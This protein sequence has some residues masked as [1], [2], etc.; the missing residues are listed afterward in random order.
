MDCPFIANPIDIEA[1]MIRN[2]LR[3]ERFFRPRQDMFYFPEEYLWERYRFSRLIYLDDLLGPHIRN[4][5][6]RGRALTSTQMLCAALHFFAN[7]S[8]LYNI[9]EHLGKATVCR[10]IRKVALALKCHFDGYLLGD[11]GYPCL[12]TLLTPNPD[13]QTGPQLHFNVAHSRTR[14]RVVNTIGILKARFQCLKK[15]RVTPARACDIIVSCVVLHN[16][17][18]NR[19]EPHPAVQLFPEDDHP[20][21]PAADV[22]DGRAIRDIV[23]KNL[24]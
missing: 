1:Q 18:I 8:F 21:H 4:I 15:L 2:A 7:G 20:F 5:T 23:C 6:H 3:R 12:P 22:Q 19:G 11:R 9:A 16:I 10:S 17:A 14:A 13:P 24:R